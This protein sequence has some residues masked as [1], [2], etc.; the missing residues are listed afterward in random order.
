MNAAAYLRKSTGVRYEPGLERQKVRMS[1]DMTDRPRS[2]RHA[3]PIA[4]A[5]CAG[6]VLV[7]C[8]AACAALVL[9]F[10]PFDDLDNGDV[11]IVALYGFGLALLGIVVSVLARAVRLLSRTWVRATWIVSGFAVVLV[12]YRFFS[13]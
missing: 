1:H 8:L 9:S 6:V 10:D 4:C 7:I 11:L 12:A 13:Y 3:G 2:D 5:A